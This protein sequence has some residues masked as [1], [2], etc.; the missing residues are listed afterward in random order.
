MAY[1]FG[2]D[3]TFQ[4]STSSGARIEQYDL[5]SSFLDGRELHTIPIRCGPF[6]THPLRWLLNPLQLIDASILTKGVWEEAST[7]AVFRIVT[8]EMVAIDIGAN[9]G[10]YTVLL[11]SLSRQ[12]FSFE[13]MAEPY[14]L[15]CRHVELNA[16]RN[17]RA[18][19]TAL[20][21]VATEPAEFFSNY[22]WSQ[23]SADSADQTS[24]TPQRE[25]LDSLYAE[26]LIPEAHFV[27]LDV[28]GYEKMILDGGRAYLQRCRPIVLLEVC[29]YTLRAAHGTTAQPGYIYASEAVT[30]LQELRQLGYKF[31]SEFSLDQEVAIDEIPRLVDLS[32]SSVNIVC[33]MA[34]TW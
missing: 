26:G 7:L 8:P 25:T 6:Q 16:L 20:G 10:Y 23:N 2:V 22:S 11:A 13:A 29:D 30:M 17:A 31:W 19:Q 14:Q 34:K 5:M 12:V 28:D 21:A 18:F 32:Q 33:A 3:T 27:K 9:M 4:Q 24:S 15:V 1:C